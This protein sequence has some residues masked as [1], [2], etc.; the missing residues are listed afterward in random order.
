MVKRRSSAI[1]LETKMDRFNA[2]IQNNTLKRLGVAISWFLLISLF[3]SFTDLLSYVHAAGPGE[4]CETGIFPK[5]V[6]FLNAIAYLILR[7]ISSI[8]AVWIALWLF[9][10]PRTFSKKPKKLGR[11][12]G[13]LDEDE[14]F[15]NRLSGDLN[16]SKLSN[17]MDQSNATFEEDED[18]SFPGKGPE[19]QFE[20][21]QFVNQPY[22]PNFND[23]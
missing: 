17:S 6:Y 4:T 20:A 22:Q 2:A 12:Y 21:E 16:D 3:S 8:S 9:Y 13:D 14:T 10:K 11:D 19:E 7:C 18:G 5:S 1:P 23:Y 15:V